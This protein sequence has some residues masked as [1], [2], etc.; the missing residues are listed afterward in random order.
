MARPKSR[1]SFADAAGWTLAGFGTGLLA[2]ALL[3]GWLGAGS[4]PRIRRALR[5]WRE[6]RPEARTTSGTVTL[7]LAAL[8][9]AGLDDLQLRVLGVRPGVVELHGWVTSRA[10]RARAIRLLS[11]TP[12]IELVVNSLLVRGEDD[13][14]SPGILR[15][16]DQSA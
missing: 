13:R 6:E 5:D 8:S 7:A 14:P 4:S 11:Q 15:T 16:T 2:G 3:S 9:E 10:E 1:L 12:G